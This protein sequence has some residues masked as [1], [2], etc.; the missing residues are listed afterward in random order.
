[1]T[2]RTK[3]KAGKLAGKTV[4]F[5]GK[6]GYRDIAP[7]YQRYA[8]SEGGKVVEI[9]S[10]VPDYLVVGERGG[11]PS[12][13]APKYSRRTPVFKFSMWRLSFNFSV[14]HA[15]SFL[16]RSEA[17]ELA[18]DRWKQLAEMF[19]RAG[20]MD[21]SKADLRK[22]KLSAAKLTAVTLDGTDF[23]E[24]D[25]SYADLS[26]GHPPAVQGAKFQ[27]ENLHAATIRQA[28]DCT[29]RGAQMPEAWLDEGHHFRSDFTDTKLAQVRGDHTQFTDCVF[30]KADLSDAEIERS[31]FLEADLSQADLSRAHCAKCN[32]TG[33]K[34]S[35][36]ILFRADLRE[37]ILVNAD[38]RKADLREAVL[39]GAD[40]TGAKIDGAD[41]A[42][43]S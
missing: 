19:S 43:P 25:L 32:F 41:F 1:M 8:I 40:L 28:E 10:V 30:R 16:A 2:T 29:F 18:H 11:K 36:A 26:H 6:F 7:D 3:P 24:A 34:L 42:G 21:L 13:M 27:G 17:G 15:T 4:A 23:R 12:P 20:T 33:A 22:A 5:V 38:L 35:H 14:Q 31:T 39:T 37:A 9:E